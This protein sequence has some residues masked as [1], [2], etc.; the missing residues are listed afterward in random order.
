VSKANVFILPYDGRVSRDPIFRLRFL[1][2]TGSI[3]PYFRKFLQD[4]GV[5]VSKSGKKR[6][7]IQKYC[8]RI[9]QNQSPEQNDEKLFLFI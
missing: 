9:Y 3:F 2:K 8:D 6:L 1:C 4:S 7:T 5:I